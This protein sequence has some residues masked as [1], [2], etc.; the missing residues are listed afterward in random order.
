MT[1]LLTEVKMMLEPLSDDEVMLQVCTV[2]R[3][4]FINTWGLDSKMRIDITIPL[5]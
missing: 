1:D 3:E 2:S 5:T 4:E